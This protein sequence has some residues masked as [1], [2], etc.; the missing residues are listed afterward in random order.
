MD[1]ERIDS[2]DY[3]EH[4]SNFP[5][6]KDFNEEESIEKVDTLKFIDHKTATFSEQMFP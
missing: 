6:S 4:S 2:K 5:L 3:S 1:Q